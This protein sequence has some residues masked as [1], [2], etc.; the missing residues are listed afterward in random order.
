MQTKHDY[1]TVQA[2]VEAQMLSS[3]KL[4]GESATRLIQAILTETQSI[5]QT[6]PTSDLMNKV[7]QFDHPGLKYHEDFETEKLLDILVQSR[8]LQ[9]TLHRPMISETATSELMFLGDYHGFE[10]SRLPLLKSEISRKMTSCEVVNSCTEE[11]YIVLARSGNHCWKVNKS[12]GDVKYIGKIMRKRS[13]DTLELTFLPIG[14]SQEL[15]LSFKRAK[16]K[17][18]ILSC[19]HQHYKPTLIDL[20]IT[21]NFSKGTFTEI[22]KDAFK[23]KEALKIQVEFNDSIVTHDLVGLIC[24]LQAMTLELSTY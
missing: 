8:G 7:M 24:L 5:K 12:R 2:N 19:G 15:T 23:P 22:T 21:T 10:F 11:P 3:G 1:M 18:G 20:Q 6:L 14:N 16:P 17:F 13:K 4:S 9:F